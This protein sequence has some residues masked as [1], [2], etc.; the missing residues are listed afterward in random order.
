M[1][2]PGAPQSGRLTAA[3]AMGPGLPG[4]LF[5][6]GE[7]ERIRAVAD[8]DQT[9]TISDF[10]RVDPRLLAALDILITGWECPAIGAA[11][12]NAMPRLRAIIHAG[13]T[14]KNHL[15]PEVWER[16]I[17]VTSA[18]DANAY[19]VAEYTLAAIL[20][21]G[22]GVP[23]L[24]AAY[25][26]DPAFSAADCHDI[27]NYRRT[28]GII[29]A[30]RI[31]RRVI[32]LLGQFDFTVLLH[33]PYLPNADPVLTHAE[34][35]G[36]DDLFRRS[37]IVS[38]HAPLLPETAGMVGSRQLALMSP[39]STLINTARGPIVDHEALANAVR[40]GGVRAI[41]DVTAPEPLPAG[42]PLRELPGVILTPHVAGSLGNELRR[43]GE[44]ATQEVELLAAGRP[45]RCPV[46][47]ELLVTTA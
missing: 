20:L 21:A 11:E 27:G 33:D 1:R 46:G 19:P 8:I 5:S 45:P 4:S 26:R 12:L 2:F 23:A 40:S 32:D 39:G 18:A 41:L 29:G 31:G 17:L 14:V 25:A 43:L 38:I 10:G 3:F 35:V 16:G 24:A 47:R 9:I 28:V 22:K 15:S 44:S 30:S 7:L 34:R 37:S 6:T 13:G 36:L 42:H